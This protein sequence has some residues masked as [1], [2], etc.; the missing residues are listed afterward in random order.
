[1]WQKQY[2]FTRD[3]ILSEFYAYICLHLRFY[4]A[5][6]IFF[7]MSMAVLFR[8][9]WLIWLHGWG[10]KMAC[11]VSVLFGISCLVLAAVFSGYKLSEWYA[12]F[13]QICTSA[14]NFQFTGDF[15]PLTT[16]ICKNLGQC[17]LDKLTLRYGQ[18]QQ[19]RSWW[20]FSPLFPENKILRRKF[21]RNVKS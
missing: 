6:N 20:F 18:I 11:F 13:A 2:D 15:M 4:V 9:S 19:T 1:M 16:K 14:V 21:V 8:R 5:A 17:I 12:V 3:L 7:L 10:R